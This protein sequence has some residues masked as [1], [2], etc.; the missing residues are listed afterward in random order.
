[1]GRGVPAR[2]RARPAVLERARRAV[3]RR[4]RA[5][6][7]SHGPH[8]DHP[9]RPGARS[10]RHGARAGPASG[11]HAMTLRARARWAALVTLAAAALLPLGH[12]T[13]SRLPPAALERLRREVAVRWTGEAMLA[14][15]LDRDGWDV[16]GAVAAQPQGGGWPM[17]PWSFAALLLF[18]VAGV[19]AVRAMGG[20]G[21]PWRQALGCYGAAAG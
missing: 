21:E 12:A 13:A 10:G 1:M 18:V 6:H 3:A 2:G 8:R 7:R 4:R 15:L 19:Q 17:S 14:P 20:T 9:R 16:V 11:R 5:A